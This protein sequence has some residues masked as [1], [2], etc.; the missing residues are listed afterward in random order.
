[1]DDDQTVIIK[2]LSNERD[3]ARQITTRLQAPFAEYDYQ[4]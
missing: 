2:F 1:M 4:L 3:D